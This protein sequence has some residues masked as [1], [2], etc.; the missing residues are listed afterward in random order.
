MQAL[1]SQLTD[2]FFYFFL[3]LRKDRIRK[4]VKILQ[5][6]CPGETPEQLARRLIA[7]QRQLSFLGGALLHL[8]MFFPSLGAVLQG[9][10]AAGGAAV[11]TRMHLYLILEIALLYGQDIDDQ[12]RVPEM[13]RVVLATGVA[14]GAPFLMEYFGLNPLLALPTAALSAAGLAQLIGEQAI[15]LYSH[16]SAPGADAAAAASPASVSS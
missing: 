15:H 8:P 7:S 5:E 11:L 1:Q 14:V 3:R 12:A 4:V 2:D 16:L 13:V 6:R 9:L 10:G